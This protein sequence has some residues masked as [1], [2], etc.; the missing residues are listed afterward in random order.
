MI[1]SFFED[2]EAPENPYA[3]QNAIADHEMGKAFV[4]KKQFIRKNFGAY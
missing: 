2:S 3:N 1:I 4:K